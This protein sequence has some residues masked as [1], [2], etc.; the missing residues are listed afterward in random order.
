M[1]K[2]RGTEYHRGVSS[3]CAAR[4]NVVERF[5]T[6][7][8]IDKPAGLRSVPGRQADAADSVERRARELWPEAE[9]PIMVHRLDAETSGLMVLGL[10]SH[11]HRALSIQF[12]KRKVGKTYVAI[13][14][15][16]VAD[17][18][19]AV[20]LPLIV[21]WPNRPRQKVCHDRGKPSRTLYRVA[22][23]LDA[24]T[25]VDFRPVTGRMHQLQNS[26]GPRSAS[27]RPDRTVDSRR[28]RGGYAF[29]SPARSGRNLTR[30]R[31]RRS[32]LVRLLRGP[33]DG[34]VTPDRLLGTRAGVGNPADDNRQVVMSQGGAA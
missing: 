15:G 27:F 20:D 22:E 9:G 33:H 10:T 6:F 2:C 24:R 30:S 34:A 19:G 4:L 32:S 17:Q 31:P 14:D 3:E 29:E 21:D 18:E 5:E 26:D 25:R 11:A 7:A 23:R 28:I 16:V 1:K 8:V 12:M 13:L